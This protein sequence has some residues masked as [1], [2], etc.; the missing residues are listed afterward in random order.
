VIAGVLAAPSVDEIELA[1]FARAF[2]DAFFPLVSG[3]FCQGG[4]E[5]LVGALRGAPVRIPSA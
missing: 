5:L 4:I 3:K 1:L 2:F